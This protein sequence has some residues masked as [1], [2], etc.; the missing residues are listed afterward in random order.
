MRLRP[1]VAQ[2]VAVGRVGRVYFIRCAN[3]AELMSA[4]MSCCYMSVRMIP[5]STSPRPTRPVP[6]VNSRNSS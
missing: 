5:C 4:S 3:S 6:V 1:A 2:G